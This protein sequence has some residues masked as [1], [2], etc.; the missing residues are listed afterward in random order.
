MLFFVALHQMKSFNSEISI[1]CCCF[2]YRFDKGKKGLAPVSF[3][4]IKM[5]RKECFWC[6]SSFAFPKAGS[7][8]SGNPKES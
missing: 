7:T 5:L 4:R 2:N 8:R 1:V 6:R 3:F